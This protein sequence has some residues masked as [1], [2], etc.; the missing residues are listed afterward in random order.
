MPGYS[1]GT[2]ITGHSEAIQI[3]FDPKIISFEKILDIFSGIRIIQL[4]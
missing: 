3:K 1:G 2:G 4:L